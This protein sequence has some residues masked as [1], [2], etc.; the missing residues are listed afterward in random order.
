VLRR[1][2]IIATAEPPL[3]RRERARIR[4]EAEASARAQAR[5]RKIFSSPEGM[6]REDLA[7][8]YA[9]DTGV[10]AEKA[11]AAIRAEIMAAAS[12]RVPHNVNQQSGGN[13]L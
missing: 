9:F 4:A 8:H 2:G 11:I 3:T 5:I 10:S 12:N 7:S 1:A 6:A 13:A